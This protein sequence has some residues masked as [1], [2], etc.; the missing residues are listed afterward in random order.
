M[1][2]HQMNVLVVGGAG[3]VGGALTDLLADGEH[4]VRVYDALLYEECYRKPVDFVFGDIRD[5]EVL[6][7]QLQWA[8][9][10]VWLA[11]L[12][13][14][15]A[16]ALHPEV[17]RCIN[18][19]TVRWMSE[20][21]DG[22]ILFLSTCSV[23]GAQDGLLYEASRTAPLSVYAETKL[24]AET[25]VA[26]KDALVFRL[27]TLFGVGDP[28]ARIRLDLVVNALTVRARQHGRV[29]VYGGEQYRPLL[30]VRD[31]ARAIAENLTTRHRG[32]FNLATENVRIIDLAERVRDYIPG[33][34][35]ER[36]GTTYEDARNYRVSTEK[37]EEILRFT[38]ELSIDE[39]IDEIRRLADSG[40]IKDID[41]PRYS[42]KGF[43]SL[44]NTHVGSLYQQPVSQSEYS[45]RIAA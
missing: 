37:A 8:D 13:G 32:V 2:N 4:N 23:Y 17:S 31:A 33:I 18:Q 24:Q 27:G 12:V 42:N 3:Y 9:V 39:G 30:H 41:N 36:V 10:V 21:F 19:E 28:F 1:H 14:D 22:R 7:E 44:H 45:R 5:R 35:I 6:L 34:L 40:R 38:P 29:T 15:A 16:C 25:Y 11:A 43:L 20:S 26:D